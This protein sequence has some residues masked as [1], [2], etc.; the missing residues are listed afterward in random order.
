MVLV[1]VNQD[2]LQLDPL[3]GG[4]HLRQIYSSLPKG[5]IATWDRNTTHSANC[6]VGAAPDSEYDS[7]I[8]TLPRWGCFVLIGLCVCMTRSV[9]YRGGV[10]APTNVCALD[11][12]NLARKLNDS[13]DGLTRTSFQFRCVPAK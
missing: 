12:P 5:T 1:L 2:H 13:K 7:R 8:R 3:P 11:A 4:V 6:L 10:L 9:A